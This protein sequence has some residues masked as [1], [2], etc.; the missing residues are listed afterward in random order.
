LSSAAA[1][2]DNA[3]V[4]QADG[5]LD[6]AIERARAGDA[7]GFD[8]LFREL[9]GSV[10]GYLRARRVSDPE[11]IT[12]DVFLRAFRSIQTFKGDAARFRSWLFTIAHNAALDDLRRRRRR[13]EETPLSRAREESG[14]D[15]EAEVMARLAHDRVHALLG[16]LSA[17]QRDVL[18]LRIVGDLSVEQVAAVLG[19]SYE[20]VRA[21]QR[22]G[23]ASV[24]R[25]ISSQEA[26][27]R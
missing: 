10:A 22:R 1:L 4:T 23:L 17:D 3:P 21:L 24:L 27:R 8:A 26:V 7:A 13:A 6:A 2:A 18:V 14:G 5:I 19:K 9:A 12:N 25:A 11:G 16:A 15:V 20:A